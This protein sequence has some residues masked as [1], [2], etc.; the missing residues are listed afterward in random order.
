MTIHQSVATPDAAAPASP[1]PA[2]FIMQ[3][4][5][6]MWLSRALWGAARLKLADAIGDTPMTPGAIAFVCDANADSVARILRTLAAFGIFVQT[7]EGRFSH[8]DVSRHL[9]SDHPES[10]RSFVEA[11][12]GNEHYAAWS[13]LEA[14]M[15]TGRAGFDVHYGEPVFDYFRKH[16]ESEKLFG[17]AMTAT[18]RMVDRAVLEAHDFGR[19]ALAVD[20]GGSHA[21]LLSGLLARHPGSRGIV[22]D[23]PATVEAGRVHWQG[24]EPGRR[25][26]AVGGDFF[27]E[28]P[29]GDLYLLK[30]ILHDWTDA[31][32]LQILRTIRAAA[33]TDARVAICEMVLP[34][35]PQ[36]H[37]GFL[38]D[39]NMLAQT[40]GRERMVKEYDALLRPAGFR[41]A[42]VTPTASP[43]SVIEA[44]AV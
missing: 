43:M 12:F 37:P 44:V 5:T 21:S 2:E 41:I 35:T 10:Q 8:N 34:E 26:E 38:M 22:F 11:V 28:V 27:R 30:F 36:P 25:I 4:G 19:F 24:T 42:R 31:Q 3:I 23:L 17:E 18:T 40:G 20:V 7:S 15:R 9:R 13:E 6:G 1:T 14:T 32:C 33:E 16:P 29:A 39:L